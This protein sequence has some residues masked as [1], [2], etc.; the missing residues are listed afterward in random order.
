MSL[1]V[2]HLI[3]SPYGI[4]GAEKLLLDMSGF[5]DRKKFSIYYC[6]LFGSPHKK[7]MFS[8]SLMEK[9]L[10][11]FDI[12]GY[13]FQNIPSIIARL[14]SLVKSERIDIV[15][16]HLL[17][18]S[19]IGGIVGKL[20]GNHKIIVTQHYT[21]KS[22]DKFFQKTIDRTAIK[23]ADRLIAVSSAVKADLLENGVKENKICVI[24]NGIHLKEFDQKA[25]IK[26]CL[27]SD[28]KKQ[29]KFII[30]AV[31]NLHKRKDY[32]N[33]IK[34]MKEVV[35]RFPE[36]HLVIIGEGT[37]RTTLEKMIEK[38]NLRNNI[39]LVGFQKNVSALIKH[40]DLYVHPAKSEPFGIAI[41]EAM[42]ISKCVIATKVEGVIDIIENEINGFL[43]PPQDSHA[44]AERICKA[45]ENPEQT[46]EIGR[47]ARKRVEDSFIIENTVKSYQDLYEEIV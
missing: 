23:M 40:F 12:P 11:K 39:T 1:K 41:L 5:Y 30:G 26:N 36:T 42:A 47:N 29:G 19:L 24:H 7:D 27:F 33:L 46:A 22:L 35:K 14:R 25:N 38:K 4:G 32:S 10:P 44:I 31:G 21:H 3:S 20:P 13:R 34:A 45:I 43:V 18:A 17:H 2:L 6:N 15:Q 16:T 8:E 37:E 28:L 9:G